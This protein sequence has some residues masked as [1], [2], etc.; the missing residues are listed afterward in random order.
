MLKFKV[1]PLGSL[2]KIEDSGRGEW[3]ELSENIFSGFGGENRIYVILSHMQS[4]DVDIVIVFST[5]DC[6]SIVF[7]KNIS[8]RIELEKTINDYLKEYTRLYFVGEL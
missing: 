3:T 5:I 1:Y 6:P 2:I 8:D 4:G 7:K